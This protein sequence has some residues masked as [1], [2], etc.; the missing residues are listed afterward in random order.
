MEQVTDA[1]AMGWLLLLHRHKARAC[2][3][4]EAWAVSKGE[5]WG[6]PPPSITPAHRLSP[7]PASDRPCD[8]ELIRAELT[9][10]FKQPADPRRQE[11]S[12]VS[13]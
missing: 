13:L 11:Q 4:Q 12:A 9:P 3:L 6:L 10:T 2:H 5:G 8:L 1:R 7:W